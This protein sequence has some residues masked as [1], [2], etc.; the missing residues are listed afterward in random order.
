MHA[1]NTAS[2][3]VSLHVAGS[4]AAF[5]TDSP[6]S[7]ITT[8]ESLTTAWNSTFPLLSCHM[9]LATEGPTGSPCADRA[10]VAPSSRGTSGRA[11]ACA[12]EEASRRQG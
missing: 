10:C 1:R 9:L 4:E 5:Y 7:M 6:P 2:L 11:S 8:L 12:L 3:A